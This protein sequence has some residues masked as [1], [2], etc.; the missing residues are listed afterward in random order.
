VWVSFDNSSQDDKVTIKQ[1][2][3]EFDGKND[4]E[5]FFIDEFIPH[6]ERTYNCGGQQSLRYLC[7]L[8]SSGIGSLR[9]GFKFPHYFAAISAQQASLPFAISPKDIGSADWNSFGCGL[10]K[11]MTK[12]DDPAVLDAAAM[13]SFGATKITDIDP[14]FWR[15]CVSPLAMVTEYADKIRESGM[16]IFL[17]VG[18]TD[19]AYLYNPMELLHRVLWYHRIRHGYHLVQ[20][21]DHSGSSW[22][23]RG[24]EAMDF[25]YR[26]LEENRLLHFYIM[27]KVFCQMDH[28]MRL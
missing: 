17:D 28:P 14:Q 8:C 23:R 2:H 16:K 3:K 12:K 19:F 10:A 9:F 24:P 11:E 6:M 15:E 21:A 22:R 18:D 25:L 1:Y 7:G 5:K 20:D 26:V 13:A 4:C 27:Q